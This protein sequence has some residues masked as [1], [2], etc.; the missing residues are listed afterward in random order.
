[1]AAHQDVNFFD[2]H[3]YSG[4]SLGTNQEIY[5]EQNILALT[6]TCVYALNG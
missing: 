2:I 1:M 4:N 6:L 3:A 5:L